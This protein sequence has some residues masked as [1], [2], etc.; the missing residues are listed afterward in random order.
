MLIEP[1]AVS[2]ML[3]PTEVRDAPVPMVIPFAAVAMPPLILMAPD[4]VTYDEVS[5]ATGSAPFGVPAVTT[6]LFTATAV[7][8]VMFK[9][10]PA[11]V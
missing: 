2:V 9:L 5:W 1:V 7:R 4:L 8:P 11:V 10:P 6:A 3:P